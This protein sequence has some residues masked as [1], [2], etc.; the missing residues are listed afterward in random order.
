MKFTVRTTTMTIV[1]LAVVSA[2]YAYVPRGENTVSHAVGGVAS[3][4]L[5]QEIEPGPRMG[6]VRSTVEQYLSERGGAGARTHI[7]SACTLACEAKYEDWRRNV[8]HCYD[9]A[10][11]LEHC[12]GG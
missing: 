3:Y 10:I 11:C 8:D 4:A 9:V 2:A 7:A 5:R 12:V 6:D 1:S